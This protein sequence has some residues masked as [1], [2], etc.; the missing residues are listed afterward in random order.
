M[1]LAILLSCFVCIHL[2]PIHAND[3]EPRLQALDDTEPRLR[4]LDYTGGARLRAPDDT[5]IRTPTGTR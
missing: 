2:I 3:S 5:G 4:A 1:L